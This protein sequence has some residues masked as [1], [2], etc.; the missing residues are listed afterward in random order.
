MSDEPFVLGSDQRILAACTVVLIQRQIGSVGENDSTAEAFLRA[1]A[2]RIVKCCCIKLHA[3]TLRKQKSFHLRGI[4]SIAL[5]DILLP[6]KQ[7][8]QIG[9]RHIDL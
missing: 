1:V 8:N 7:Q 5:F 4:V 6:A 2:G 3:H 9:S